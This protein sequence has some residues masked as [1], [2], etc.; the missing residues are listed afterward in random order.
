[1][2]GKMQQMSPRKFCNVFKFF[3]D[4]SHYSSETEP[5]NTSEM[6]FRFSNAIDNVNF[7]L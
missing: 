6:Y 2:I 7:F 4:L 1:M 5:Q 3:T